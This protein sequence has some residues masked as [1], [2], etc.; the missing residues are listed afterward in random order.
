MFTFSEWALL[1]IG[2][3]IGFGVRQG[4]SVI[5]EYLPAGWT[6]DLTV[7]NYDR[8]YPVYVGEPAVS[9]RSGHSPIDTLIN[10]PVPERYVSDAKPIAQAVEFTP[11]VIL[12]PF[13]GHPPNGKSV[14]TA[15]D[16]LSVPNGLALWAEYTAALTQFEDEYDGKVTRKDRLAILRAWGFVRWF[17]KRSAA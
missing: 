4:M 9:N 7:A 6:N 2:A 14:W 12:N 13:N 3:L 8:D 1:V 10:A 17:E 5:S 11:P 16:I 15:A